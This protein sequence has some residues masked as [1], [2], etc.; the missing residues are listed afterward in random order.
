MNLFD[1]IFGQ[2]RYVPRPTYRFAQGGPLIKRVSE[3]IAMLYE[4]GGERAF[5]ALIEIWMNEERDE[6]A[7]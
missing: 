7:V 4:L 3:R 5:P 2:R 6:G 1:L